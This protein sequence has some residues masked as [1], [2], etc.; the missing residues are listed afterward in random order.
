MQLLGVVIGDLLFACAGYGVMVLENAKH[1]L[2]EALGVKRRVEVWLA[3]VQHIQCIE[4]RRGEKFTRSSTDLLLLIRPS[5]EKAGPVGV[6][7]A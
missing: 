7:V 6:R 1:V 2:H 5:G 3:L 4:L